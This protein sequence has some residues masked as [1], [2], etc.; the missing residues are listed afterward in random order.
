M[1]AVLSGNVR[2]FCKF[3]LL[4]L[5]TW[6]I[7]PAGVTYADPPEWAPAHGW[8][9]KQARDDHERH[10]DEW[11]SD[12]RDDNDDDDDEHEHNGWRRHRDWHKPT[13]SNTPG[14][15]GRR[16]PKDYG[17]IS[18]HCDYRAVGAVV[19]GVIGGAVGARVGNDE[20]RPIAILLGA[21]IGAVAGANVGRTI[22]EADRACIGHSLELTQ[23]GRP[24]QWSNPHTGASYVVTPHA[25]FEHQGRVCREFDV[26][27][28]HEGREHPSHGRACQIDGGWQVQ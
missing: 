19:G 8:R 18:G 25:G 7:L 3:T 11:R 14:Y 1:T 26:L 24:V 21:V 12:R 16:W 22:E 28:S 9:K 6:A 15:S 10:R 20:N 13:H 23:D 4:G 17:V 5:M 27:V 2:N